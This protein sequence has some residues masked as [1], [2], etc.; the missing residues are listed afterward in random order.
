MVNSNDW[1]IAGPDLPAV[2]GEYA[3]PLAELASGAIAAI[4]LRRVY[5]ESRCRRLIKYLSDDALLYDPREGMPAEFRQHAIP[6]GFYREGRSTQPDSAWQTPATMDRPRIDIG[7][8]LGYRGSD[9]QAFLAHSRQTHELFT[10]IFNDDDDPIKLLYDH[11][12]SLAIGKRVMTAHESD[13]SQYGPAIIRAHYGG[14]T[15]KPHFDSV[16][17]R[18]KRADYAVHAFEHQFAGILVLQN[19]Q[20]GDLTAQCVLHRCFW[21]TEIDHHLKDDTFHDYARQ[22]NIAN[23]EVCLEPGDLYFFNTRL[24]HEVPGVA[25]ELPRVVLATFIGYSEDRDDVFVW[26]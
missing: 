4:V 18:E 21:D 10:E 12:D 1:P 15:Y 11:L 2:C 19:T 25:G 9:K 14:H 23:V 6:E 22:Q 17:L 8:S 3:H 24:I 16:R 5:P 13:G 20:L 7:T 26:S